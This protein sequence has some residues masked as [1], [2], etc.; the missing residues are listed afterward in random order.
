MSFGSFKQKPL[1]LKYLLPKN[2]N[3][4]YLVFIKKIF[5]NEQLKFNYIK[6]VFGSCIIPNIQTFL[7]TRIK[8]HNVILLELKSN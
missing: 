4:N 6:I 3:K 8:T 7:N 1:P 2:F 5:F